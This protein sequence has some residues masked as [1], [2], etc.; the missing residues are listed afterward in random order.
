MA[1]AGITSDYTGRKRDISILQYPDAAILDAQTVTPSFGK[2]A[3]FCAGVQSLVQ[4]YAII[5]LTNLGSQEMYPNFGTNYLRN[6]K[7]YINKSTSKSSLDCN[8]WSP[9]CSFSYSRLCYN[10]IAFSFYDV[11]I[12]PKSSSRDRKFSF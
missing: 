4:K 6:Q 3:R 8:V 2:N 9:F 1:I 12:V 7:K 11:I 10:H 5:L